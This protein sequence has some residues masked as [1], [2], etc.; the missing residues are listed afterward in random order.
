MLNL[1]QSFFLFHPVFHIPAVTTYITDNRNFSPQRYGRGVNIISTGI[2]ARVIRNPNEIDSAAFWAFS[3]TPHQTN[4]SHSRAAILQ[5]Q[6]PAN[7]AI[8][9]GTLASFPRQLPAKASLPVRDIFWD[10]AIN[11][12]LASNHEW[13]K[14][15]PR[16]QKKLRFAEQRKWQRQS[17]AQWRRPAG[18][19]GCR[20]R[21]HLR[22]DCTRKWMHNRARRNLSSDWAETARPALKR[23]R[24]TAKYKQ[25]C[26]GKEGQSQGES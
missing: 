10:D 7:K 25:A 22:S 20:E 16:E 26:S 5:V 12:S 13:G 1:C 4:T 14:T 15:I 9:I 24:R 19:A 18:F 8:G 23:G 11:H 6:Q 21:F 3:W 2:A 17:F